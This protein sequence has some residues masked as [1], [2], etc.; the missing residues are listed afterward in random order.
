MTNPEETSEGKDS[1]SGRVLCGPPPL[2]P[3]H[4]A[5]GVD[6]TLIRWMLSLT[7]DERLRVLQDSVAAYAVD[8]RR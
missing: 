5:R 2:E 8:D 1:G 3:T 4:D 6:L 7:P